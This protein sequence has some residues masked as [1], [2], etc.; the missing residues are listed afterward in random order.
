VLTYK[1]S[2][3]QS[4]NALSLLTT[5]PFAKMAMEM[6]LT[7]ESTGDIVELERTSS[8][9]GTRPSKHERND[10]ATYIEI[11]EIDAGNYELELLIQR[12]MFLPTNVFPTCLEFTFVIEYIVRDKHHHDEDGMYEVLAVR[13]LNIEQLLPS[14][15][16]VI[17]VNFD[18]EVVLDDLVNGLAD[19]Y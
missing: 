3:E 12:S 6:T 1:L 4:G 11:P 17:E 18:K 5:Y 7:D 16:T 8:L 2:I 13:P 19:R 14:D 10:M 15:E 9:Q